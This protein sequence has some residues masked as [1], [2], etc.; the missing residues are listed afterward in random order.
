MDVSLRAFLPLESGWRWSLARA[1][2]DYPLGA[3]PG[4]R[5]NFELL[6]YRVGLS[7]K[8]MTNRWFTRSVQPAFWFRPCIFWVVRSGKGHSDPSLGR[9]PINCTILAVYPLSTL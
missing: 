8:W 3:L 5:E 4:A 9:W 6:E 1:L 2:S 7:C